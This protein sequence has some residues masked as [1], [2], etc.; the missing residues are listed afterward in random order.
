MLRLPPRFYS[1]NTSDPLSFQSRLWSSDWHS[2]WRISHRSAL[3]DGPAFAFDDS[4]QRDRYLLR[5]WLYEHWLF[6]QPFHATGWPVS[7][8]V[9]PTGSC[10]RAA[11]GSAC[12][13]L[14]HDVLWHTHEKRSA[15]PDQRSRDLSGHDLC[16]PV[17]QSHT[18]GSACALYQTQLA[19]LVSVE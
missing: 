19:G 3:S 1:Q 2:T 5:G 18:P 17:S 6:H 15:G 9:A 8:P 4:A 12:R 13:A 11:C 7:T 10:I 16:W 14:S